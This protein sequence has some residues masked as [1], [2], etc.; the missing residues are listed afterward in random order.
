MSMSS[1]KITVIRQIMISM[2]IQ[3]RY[4]KKD[5][6]LSQTDNGDRSLFTEDR[7]LFINMRE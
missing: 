4:S 1:M 7:S 3:I 2:Q 6:M 5:R